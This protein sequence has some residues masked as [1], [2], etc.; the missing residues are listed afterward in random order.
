MENISDPQF[1]KCFKAMK[2]CLVI[3]FLLGLICTILYATEV[4]S[5]VDDSDMFTSLPPPE[6]SVVEKDPATEYYFILIFNTIFMI[7]GAFGFLGYVYLKTF[8]VGF[9]ALL[10]AFGSFCSLVYCIAIAIAGADVNFLFLILFL[11]G[12]GVGSFGLVITNKLLVEHSESC[13]VPL[14]KSLLEDQS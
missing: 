14:K 5:S 13:E 11:Y 6:I 12:L 10:T 3:Q 1:A 7:L 4:V 8:I 9:H 2:F